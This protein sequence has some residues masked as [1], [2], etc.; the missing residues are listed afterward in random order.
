M[1]LRRGYGTFNPRIAF[2][3]SILI[4]DI[5]QIVCSGLQIELMLWGFCHFH[6][7]KLGTSVGVHA[8]ASPDANTR[9]TEYASPA[10]WPKE[11]DPG[12]DSQS[13]SLSVRNGWFGC[14]CLR[15]TCPL[16]PTNALGA[17]HARLAISFCV[18]PR[19]TWRLRNSSKQL[20][21]IP[22]EVF[23]ACDAGRR[24]SAGLGEH[25]RPASHAS[26]RTL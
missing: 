8:R 26:N 13:P 11:F 7:S 12:I 3:Q 6:K 18:S 15:T 1:K 25:A 23:K 9:L 16:S 17:V 14:S 24:K 19:S 5:R 4:E 22:V 2:T 10:R 21:P 20:Q